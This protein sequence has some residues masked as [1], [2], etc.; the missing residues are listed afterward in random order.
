L[1]Y[2]KKEAKKMASLNDNSMIKKEAKKKLG[3]FKFG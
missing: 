3:I 2:N 1:L